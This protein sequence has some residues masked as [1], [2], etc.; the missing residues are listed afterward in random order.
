MSQQHRGKKK[1]RRLRPFG[2]TGEK[3]STPQHSNSVKGKKKNWINQT[4]PLFSFKLSFFLVET[5]TD[6]AQ[7]ALRFPHSAG[8]SSFRSSQSPFR[9]PHTAGPCCFRAP[10]PAGLYFVRA[11]SPLVV[12]ESFCKSR[13][14]LSVQELVEGIHPSYSSEKKS[15]SLLEPISHLLNIFICFFKFPICILTDS[16][17]SRRDPR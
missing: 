9:L 11:S 7:C 4:T 2:N 6:K 3:T 15:P 16:L 17:N 5:G 8:P 13:A 1:K 14:D 12:M 10:H